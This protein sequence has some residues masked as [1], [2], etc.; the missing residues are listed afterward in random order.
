MKTLATLCVLAGG[1]LFVPFPKAAIATVLWAACR[2]HPAV[3]AAVILTLVA[4]WGA[5]NDLDDPSR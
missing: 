1:F 2:T 5:G 4:N 3:T